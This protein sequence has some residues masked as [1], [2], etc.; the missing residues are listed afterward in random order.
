MSRGCLI[1]RN[2]NTYCRCEALKSVRL[3]REFCVNDG[4]IVVV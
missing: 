3:A 1:I 4:S 2:N